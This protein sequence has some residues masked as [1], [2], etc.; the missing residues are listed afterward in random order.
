MPPGPY[1]PSL[2]S[3]FLEEWKALEGEASGFNLSPSPL[4]SD[5]QGSL[6]ILSDCC[7][8]V[9]PNM[10]GVGSSGCRFQKYIF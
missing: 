3:S 9:A 6:P 8:D 1:H 4:G 7:G 5:L 2:W 10:E